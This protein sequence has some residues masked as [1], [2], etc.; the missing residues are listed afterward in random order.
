MRDVGVPRNAF[1]T[2]S[3]GP[4]FHKA[5][6][7]AHSEPWPARSLVYAAASGNVAC[8]QQ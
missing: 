7:Q 8:R 1:A 2:S 3:G 6:G 4:G 5:W